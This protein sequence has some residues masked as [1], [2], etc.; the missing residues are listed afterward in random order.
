VRNLTLT[1]QQYVLAVPGAEP[2]LS[3]GSSATPCTHLTHRPR[4]SLVSFV[5][6]QDV[7]QSIGAVLALPI[8]PYVNDRVGRKHSITIGSAIIVVGVI[9]QTASQN[10]AMFFVARI[11]LGIGASMMVASHGPCSR[12]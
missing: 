7:E 8:V 2:E 6:I 1:R 10:F 3:F 5:L 11:I 4:A 9:L 12:G